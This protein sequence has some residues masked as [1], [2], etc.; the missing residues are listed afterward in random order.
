MLTY[1]TILPWIIGVRISAVGDPLDQETI[2]QDLLNIVASK[3]VDKWKLFGAQLD[4]DQATL[5]QIS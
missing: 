1:T 2:L 4:I 3:A 5:Q